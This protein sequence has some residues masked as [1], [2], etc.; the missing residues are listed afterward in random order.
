LVVLAG[1]EG[2]GARRSVRR[3]MALLLPALAGLAVE[4]F[5]RS[6]W[7]RAV[8]ARGW[9]DLKTPA[10]LDA[11][12]LLE[13]A[14]QVAAVAWQV[15]AV[16]WLVVAIGS[17]AVALSI[18]RWRGTPEGRTLAGAGAAALT[19]LLVV[20]AVRHVRENAYNPRY[21]CLGLSLAA[22]GTS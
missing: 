3:R 6:S 2:T 13:N 14:W 9:P 15:G 16:P 10:S 19:S 12:H 8:R 7:H 18:R 17:A 21:L 5:V 4:G 20:M 1:V 11:G 22:L